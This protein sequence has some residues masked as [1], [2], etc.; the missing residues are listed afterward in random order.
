MPVLTPQP[1]S[2]RSNHWTVAKRLVVSFA[3]VASVGVL[4]GV[5]TW[6]RV[7]AIGRALGGVA[8]AD[9]QT[10][11]L[12][13]DIGRQVHLLHLLLSTAFAVLAAGAAIALLVTRNISGALKRNI[14][15]LTA[16]AGRIASASR[17]I[18]QSSRL[19]A[20][21]ANQ[22]ASSLEESGAAL[23]EIAG[24]SKNN[25]DGA[26]AAKELAAKARAA[27]DRGSADVERMDK[28]MQAIESSSADIGKIIKTIDQ[29]AFQTNILSLNAAVEAA[30]AG[31]AGAG[32]A[33]V[34]DE[35][36]KLAQSSAEAA[37]ETAQKIEVAL[38]KTA[39]GSSW[40]GKASLRLKD[41]VEVVH[42][43][44]KVMGEIA[45]ASAEQS[46][47]VSQMKAGVTRMDQVTQENAAT[48]TESAAAA[49][50]M[51]EQAGRLHAV[52]AGLSQV[53]GV[54]KAAMEA[55][56]Q[57]VLAGP[58]QAA[59]ADTLRPPPSRRIVGPA[60]SEAVTSLS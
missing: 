38:A 46:R 29:I 19:L 25:A 26:Q 6:L 41:V 31:E 53:I 18:S 48:A 49:E 27:A 1:D 28:A 15:E 21:R 22:E 32:F 8:P 33:V 13:E 51:D 47:G 56:A 55:G 30:R 16:S 5:L 35:V 7:E 52:V 10:A 4:L 40:S 20:D 44:D 2:L 12:R 14:S 17:S 23:E 34:A 37:K 59:A 58:E 54:D 24:L 43:L 39:E 3:G 45:A 11:A 50:R 60:R 9:A 36:R 42:E 57:T